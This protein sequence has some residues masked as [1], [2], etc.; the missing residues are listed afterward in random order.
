MVNF[1]RL[2]AAGEENEELDVNAVFAK[3]KQLGGKSEDKG[4][5]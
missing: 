2:D 1:K 3:L 4:D 5:N